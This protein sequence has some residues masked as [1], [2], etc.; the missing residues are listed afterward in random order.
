M[1]LQPRSRFVRQNLFARLM[2]SGMLSIA[3]LLVSPYGY[4]ADSGFAGGITP[5]RFELETKQGELLRRSFKLYNLSSRPQQFKVRTV[6]WQFSPEGQISFQDALAGDSC[7]EWVRLERR[8]VSVVPDPQQPRNFR[9]EVQVPADA[10][11]RQC[12][13][14]LMVESTSDA[15]DT[16]FADGALNLPITGRIAVIVYLNIGDVQPE[17]QFGTL[18][19]R[20]VN[21]RRFPTMEVHN[22][23]EAHGRLDAD[24]VALHKDGSKTQLSIDTTPIL[25]HQTRYLALM[26]ESGKEL[27]YPL[28]ITGK[29]YNDSGSYEVQ[30]ELQSADPQFIARD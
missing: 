7:R 5:S 20:E 30:Q 10:E 1:L 28:T 9:F 22:S 3:S 16:N 27:T 29:L 13:F 26:P 25:P 2:L 19:V 21:T 24:L 14:A 12:R 15:V 23:G 6:E 4:G 11:P 8:K 17:L 18:A